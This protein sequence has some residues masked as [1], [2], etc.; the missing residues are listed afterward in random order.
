MNVRGGM[1]TPEQKIGFLLATSLAWEKKIPLQKLGSLGIKMNKELETIPVYKSK[2]KW[3]FIAGF[4]CGTIIGTAII[5]TW[6]R[7]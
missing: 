6:V 4:I 2:L 3:L 5:E 1:E 7:L